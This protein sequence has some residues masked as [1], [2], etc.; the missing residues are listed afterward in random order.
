MPQTHQDYSA[1]RFQSFD[2]ENGYEC[3]LPD[4]VREQLEKS[5]R[6]QSEFARPK[7]P[8]MLGRKASPG[9]KPSATWPLYLAVLI[10][11]VVVGGLIAAWRPQRAVE[12]APVQAISLPTATPQPTVVHRPTPGPAPRTMLTKGRVVPRAQLVSHSVPRAQL[13]ALP[14]AWPPLFV[15]GRYLATMPYDNLEVMATFRGWLPSQDDLPSHPNQIGDMY[16]VGNAPFVWLFPPGASRAD[17]I[18]P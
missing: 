4:N 15:G 16:L 13:V 3:E 7:R 2:T 11:V 6:R 14:P 17:W 1:G 9:L 12:R 5:P 8:R 10:A 18:H